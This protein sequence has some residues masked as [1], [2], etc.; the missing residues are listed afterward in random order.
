MSKVRM[1]CA[2]CGKHFKSASAK[3][4]L[5][6]D[7]EARERRERAAAKAGGAKPAQ[8]VAAVAPTTPKIVGPGAHLLVP[9]MTPVP[10][11][12][13]VVIETAATRP[14]GAERSQIETTRDG[15]GVPQQTPGHASA[16]AQKTVKPSRPQTPKAPRAPKPPMPP[17]EVTEA[18]RGAIE[19]HYL[20]LAHPVEFDGIRTQIAVDLNVPKVAVKRVV[21][22][23]RE[24]MQLPSWWELQAYTGSPE[25]LERIR[26]AYA[27]L[28][29]VPEVGIHKQIAEELSLSPLVVYQGIRHIRAEMRLPQYNPPELHAS[30]PAAASM[31]GSPGGA[32]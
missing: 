18:V 15:S 14:Q 22:E 6:P 27:P 7:C 19:N 31:P 13:E 12:P 30:E 26:R 25:D 21:R 1:K 4:T 29:P 8:L 20:E 24:R 3:Q 10:A 5:C 9:G 32:E 17:F 23:L 16:R 28:L 2:R 11:E